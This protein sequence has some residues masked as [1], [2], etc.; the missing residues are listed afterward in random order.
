M[1]RY[2]RTLLWF[3]W[4]I[5]SPLLAL[6]T[7]LSFGFC[8]SVIHSI[9]LLAF[10]KIYWNDMC[11]ISIATHQLDS[12]IHKI[13]FHDSTLKY[14]WSYFD[15]LMFSKLDILHCKN[16]L[17][18]SC[19]SSLNWNWKMYVKAKEVLH[20]HSREMSVTK[21]SYFGNTP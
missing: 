17:D 10:Q 1:N 7:F 21:P 14:A 2:G 9:S 3:M 6:H 13:H 5:I 15:F 20:Q 4:G 11:L 8:S 19:L 16:L 12:S 18:S